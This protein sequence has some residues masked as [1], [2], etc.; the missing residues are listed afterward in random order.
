VSV[1]PSSQCGAQSPPSAQKSPP[2]A[3]QNSSAT[4][5]AYF[6]GSQVEEHLVMAI[7]ANWSS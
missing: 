2:E 6:K 7:V 4:Q 5:I 3:S 1:K